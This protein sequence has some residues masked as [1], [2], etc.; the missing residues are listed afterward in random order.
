MMLSRYRIFLLGSACLGFWF[1]VAA[2]EG[3]I[4]ARSEMRRAVVESFR[5]NPE[6]RQEIE[7]LT[8]SNLEVP[9]PTDSDVVILE[10]FEVNERP[11]PRGLADAIAK[12]RPLG[13]QNHSRFGTG[14][15]QKDFGKVRFSAVTILY[16]PVFLQLSW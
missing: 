3:E 8:A 12:A 4:G 6:M 7:E 1:A 2:A 11:V 14:I 16:V 9:V 15:H 13:P 5:Y 10:K